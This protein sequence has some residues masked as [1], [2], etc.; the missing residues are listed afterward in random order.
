[1]ADLSSVV[2]FFAFWEEGREVREVFGF[3]GPGRLPGVGFGGGSDP[4][5]RGWHGSSVLSAGDCVRASSAGFHSGHFLASGESSG[6][7]TISLRKIW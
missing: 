3:R 2:S 4:A 7:C 1:M 6:T 5:V